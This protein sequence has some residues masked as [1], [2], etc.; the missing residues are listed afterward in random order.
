MCR[1]LGV[2]VLRITV[3]GKSKVEEYLDTISDD[4]EEG[5]FDI[6]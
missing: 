6:I 1:Q 4:R 5:R 2:D 3:E